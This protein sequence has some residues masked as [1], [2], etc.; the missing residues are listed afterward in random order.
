MTEQEQVPPFQP[1]RGIAHA[2]FW[3]VGGKLAARLFDLA[4]LV[5]LTSILEPADFGLVAKAMT[6][7][8]IVEMITLIPVETPILRVSEPS[9]SLYDTAFTLNLLRACAIGLLLVAL[10]WPLAI[11]FKDPRLA[12]LMWWL[13]L[14]PSLRGCTSPK[15]AEF[16]RGFD[17]RPEAA[18]DVAAKLSSLVIVTIVALVTHS[19]WAIAVGTVTT[20]VVLNALS[21]V[22]APYRPRLTLHH[23]HEFKD[24]VT[25]VTLSQALQAMNWQVDAFILGRILGNDT[26]GRYAIARQLNDIPYQAL[27]IPVTR[28][29]VAAFTAA[30]DEAEQRRLWLS[31]SSAV[32]LLVGPILVSLA[33]LSPQVVFVLLGPGWHET[34]VYLFGLALAALPTLPLVPL[35][36]FAVATF[37][38]R[39]V[40]TRI[41]AEFVISVPVIVAAA[42]AFGVTGAIAARGAIAVAMFFFVSHV[43]RQELSLPI[44]QQLASHWRSAV[45]FVVLAGLLFWVRD[46]G[47]DMTD[48]SRVLTA[49]RL[50]VLALPCLVAHLLVCVMLWF[51]SGRPGGAESFLFGKVSRRFNRFA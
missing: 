24:I 11:Y 8:L 41:F 40:A 12:P 6:V 31:Y 37:R 14:A 48:G 42:L 27:A 5:I 47:A 30:E 20:S 23:W 43:I 15:M 16:T 32:L 34:D 50:T 44:G 29:M 13:A 35:N 17:M 21:Y 38:T 1:T 33:V 18:M 46:L 26:F 2:A 45:G 4:T 10:S 51:G 39:L 28:P 36:P 9:R 3:S 7:V 25:W 49:F 22:F 19:Y